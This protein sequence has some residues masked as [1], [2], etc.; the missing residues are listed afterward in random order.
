VVVVVVVVV[1]GNSVENAAAQSIGD[2]LQRTHQHSW[3]V[4]GQ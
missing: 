3:Q 4:S 2:L 1:V